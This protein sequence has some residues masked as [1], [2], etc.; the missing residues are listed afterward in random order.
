LVGRTTYP[1]FLY[2]SIP[3]F[4]YLSIFGVVGCQKGKGADGPE[5]EKGVV[6]NI[7]I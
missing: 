2:S 3:L 4:L 7:P 5:K 6:P 1:L